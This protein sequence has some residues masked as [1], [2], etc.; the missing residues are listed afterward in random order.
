MENQ[1]YGSESQEKIVEAYSK[2][3]SMPKAEFFKQL[4]LAVVQGKREGVYLETLE[5][6]SEGQAPIRLI[7]CRTSG[8]VFNLGH[9]HPAIIKALKDGI[10]GGLDIGDHHLISEQRAKLAERLAELLPG[11]ISK[12]QFCAVGGEAIDLAL[13]IA[14]GYTKRRKIVSATV[15]YHGVTGLALGAGHSKFKDTFLWDLDDF[16]Q[17]PFGDFKSLEILDESCAAVIM[18][19]I[20]ATGGILIPQQGYFQR[21]RELCDKHGIIMIA[22]EVQSGLGRTGELWALHG[23]L[24]DEEKIVP[25][26]M[27]LAKGMSAGYYPMATCSYKPFLEKVFEKDPFLH[28]STTGGSELGCFVTHTMLDIIAQDEFLHHVKSMG[29][30]FEKGLLA[31]KEKFPQVITDIRGRGLMW[32]I[33]FIED[34]LGLGYTVS[35]IKHGIFADFC[36]NDEKT[37]KIMP[38]LVVSKEEV[39]EILTRL[40]MVLV[41]M[42][43]G[44]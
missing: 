22:D 42:L 7:D 4:G 6:L 14:R 10:D 29:S 9:R 28:I 18:E 27:V 1:Y 11:E 2:Y 26:I 32:G 5:G 39:E 33:E 31:M 3:V 8:G 35:M 25:D 16:V 37:V 21:I 24:Y 40:E 38:P 20:P 34:R 12:T 13:K 19:I 23:G 41:K 36:G 44:D 30:I 15:G 17:I 43:K